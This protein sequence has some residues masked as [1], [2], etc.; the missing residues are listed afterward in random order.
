M[1]NFFENFIW[2]GFLKE[3]FFFGFTSMILALIISPLQFLKIQRQA[4]SSSYFSILKNYYEKHGLS[5]FFIGAIPFALLQFFSSGAFGFANILIN[6]I[7]FN[8]N[9]EFNVVSILIGTLIAGFFETLATFFFEMKE[10]EK[11]KVNLLETSGSAASIVFP[12][13]L[14]NSLYWV[15]S[16]ASI[17]ILNLIEKKY[18][19]N[20]STNLIFLISFLTGLIWAVLTIPFD[21]VVTQAFGSSEKLGIFDRLKKNI[22]EGGYQE[23]FKG[24]FMRVIMSTLFTIAI[25]LTEYFLKKYG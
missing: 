1:S 8:F 5:I 22:F 13:F 4:S 18:Y 6:K 21:L 17:F 19:I 9:L 12:L 15:G 2:L 10:I 16:L 3:P 25:V 14:R 11:N 20:L 7:I 24:S 23:I